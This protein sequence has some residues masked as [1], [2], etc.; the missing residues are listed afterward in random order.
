MA[1]GT[2]VAPPEAGGSPE[3]S[4]V[5]GEAEGPSDGAA[6]GGTAT[7]EELTAGGAGVGVPLAVEELQAATPARHSTNKAGMARIG[8]VR[9]S[10]ITSFP[11]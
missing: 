3:P 2:A 6:D 5:V 1:V 9:A 4:A 7:S 8:I 10:V 11:P